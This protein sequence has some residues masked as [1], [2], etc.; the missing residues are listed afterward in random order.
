M[1]GKLPGHS[2]FLF[3]HQPL[4]TFIY[5]ELERRRSKKKHFCSARAA[6]M[7]RISAAGFFLRSLQ[8]VL[9]YTIIAILQY[10][11][12][13]VPEYSSIAIL[14][15]VSW[16]RCATIPW[17]SSSCAARW[18]RRR[19]RTRCDGN[20]RVTCRRSSR[21]RPPQQRHRTTGLAHQDP[22]RSGSF[23]AQVEQAKDERAWLD[24]DDSKV[25]SPRGTV[26]VPRIQGLL[27]HS[28]GQPGRGG[29][30]PLRHSLLLSSADRRPC[31]SGFHYM[32]C[33]SDCT[34][35]PRRKPKKGGHNPI[36]CDYCQRVYDVIGPH[37]NGITRSP[38][39]ATTTALGRRR[40]D[41]RGE[42]L[43]AIATLQQK[44][45]SCRIRCGTSK[46]ATW[47]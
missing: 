24:A 42:K 29:G 5:I 13:Y 33:T 41:V 46:L 8:C 17:I 45:R 28:T 15:Q 7:S 40:N 39:A 2:A 27:S 23:P 22:R 38:S 1:G 9:Q 25:L 30:V 11:L 16:L 18:Q 35:A 3:R 21:G 44:R 31:S 47:H 6:L 37:M 34:T 43:L 36:R 4:Q 20:R 32:R 10:V 14:Q 19:G 26:L 12:E